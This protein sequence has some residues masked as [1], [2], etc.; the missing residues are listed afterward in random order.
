MFVE[1]KIMNIWKLKPKCESH[2]LS[3]DLRTTSCSS[4]FS[5]FQ[6]LTQPT[7]NTVMSRYVQLQHISHTCVKDITKYMVS[8]NYTT[9]VAC[10]AHL[11]TL[12]T[13]FMEI[14]PINQKRIVENPPALFVLVHFPWL[15]T[16]S[17]CSSIPECQNITYQWIMTQ[18]TTGCYRYDWEEKK[19]EKHPL[20]ILSL[21]WKSLISI[22]TSSHPHIMLEENEKTY[23]CTTQ[24]DFNSGIISS[25]WIWKGRFWWKWW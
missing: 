19:E 3:C 22:C 23:F 15:S 20:V 1:I 17:P 5:A 10:Y 8:P 9:M 12:L 24:G 7:N 21:P 25:Y 14:E 13:E 18:A 2:G 11:N 6:L 4:I 16:P